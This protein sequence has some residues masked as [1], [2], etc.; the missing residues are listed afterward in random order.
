MPMTVPLGPLHTSL[1]RKT[2]E[3]F[4]RTRAF[5]LNQIPCRVGC[6]ACCI[7][8]FPITILD[9]Q[10]LQ[11]G[12]KKIPKATQER[13][14]QRASEQIVAL[15]KAYP[16]L[17]RSPFLNHVDDS[18]IDHIVSDF[19]QV[20]CPAL[21]TEGRCE[22]YEY[23]PLVCRSMGI[24]VEE[25]GITYGACGVQ[26]FVPIKRVPPAQRE[27]EDALASREAETLELFKSSS[28][29][30]GEE[31]LLPYGFVL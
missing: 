19:S 3:W 15:E 18:Q 14:Q 8:P 24:P 13:L 29:C 30:A 6:H 25:N 21:G 20:P 5:L 26:T 9:S 4:S 16:E 7:G 17:A 22:I 10:R 2:D 11:E 27:E 12:L 23:R 1:A 28:G 31:V